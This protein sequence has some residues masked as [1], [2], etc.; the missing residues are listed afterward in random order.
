MSR[1]PRITVE[2]TPRDKKKIEKLVGR[3]YYNNQSEVVRAALRK[4]RA[5]K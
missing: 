5:P 4:M 3:G 2:I 1:M